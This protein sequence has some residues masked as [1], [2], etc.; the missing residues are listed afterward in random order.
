MR[1][2]WV[3]ACEADAPDDEDE[4]AAACHC[5]ERCLGWALH[6]FNKLILPAMKVSSFES[7]G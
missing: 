6:A 3:S 4:E 7:V 1:F 2:T 5:L